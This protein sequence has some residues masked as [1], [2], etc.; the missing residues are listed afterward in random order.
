[1]PS[2]VR[3]L[4]FAV[5]VGAVALVA[6]SMGHSSATPRTPQKQQTTGESVARYAADEFVAA[7]SVRPKKLSE[8]A[9][10]GSLPIDRFLPDPLSLGRLDAMAVEEL[11]VFCGPAVDSNPDDSRAGDIEWAAA[12]RI[13]QSIALETAIRQWRRSV[14]PQEDAADVKPA[15]VQVGDYECFQVPA[16]SF[17]PPPRTDGE[18]RFT[19]RTG[20]PAEQGISVGRIY[21]Y[22]SYVEGSTKAS[23]IFTLDQLDEADLVDGHL[24][25][26]LRPDVFLTYFP[27]HEYSIAQIELRNP[28]SGLRSEPIKFEA[29]SYVNHRLNVPR[30]I[31]AVDARGKRQVDLVKDLVS[32]GRL[33]VIL[34]GTESGMYLGVGPHD[35]NVRPKAFE[36]VFVSGREIVVAQSR[37]TLQ[38][39]L[40]AAA[41]P[42]SLSKR[43]SQQTGDIV[44]TANVRD[45]SQRSA[46]QRLTRL[47]GENALAG[48]L[49]D[50]VT[51]VTATV[52]VNGPL[53]ARATANF[54]DR[55][56]AARATRQLN[57]MIR[58]TK[59]KAHANIG[60]SV[61]RLDTRGSLMSLF[62]GVPMGFPDF[63]SPTGK[64]REPQLLSIIDASLD[65]IR[66]ESDDNVLTVEFTQPASLSRLPKAAQ[67]AV[68]N[69]EE[70]LAQDL[71]ERER[72]D[73]GIEMY[74]RV[75]NRFPHVPQAWFR[76][77]H[78]LA[79]N[80]SVEFDG[81][82][83]RYAWVRRGVN[84]LLDGAEQNPDTTDHIWMAARFIGWKI[85]GSDERAA[86]RRL[87][88]QDERLHE[89]IA[90]VIDVKRARSPEKKVDNWLVAKL[91]FEHCVD[92]HAGSR[93]PST[94]PPVLF[95]SRPAASQAG[96]AQA[97]SESGHWNEALRAWKEAERLHK[98]LGERAIPV[99]AS[100]PIRLNDLES[101]LARSGP[102]DATV[103]RLR[104]AR[105]LI[106]YDYWLTRCRLEQ[107]TE[108]QL[109]RRLSHEAA[110]HARRSKPRRAYDLYRESLQ[111]LSEVHKRHP[112]EMAL[113]AGEFRHVAE[114][115]RKV[116]EMLSETD[117]QPLGT[118]L[119][120]IEQ[121]QPV[122]GTPVI[123]LPRPDEGD[124]EAP[125]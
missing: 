125:K 111:A 2:Q 94:I 95:F 124:S 41:T 38:K 67:F 12:A 102:K 43:L 19:D 24:P 50:A 71:F 29:K 98:E 70:V 57:Q 35:L 86:Y 113:V 79:Y 90:K 61:N 9:Y 53:T 27:D 25:L 58:S 85:G 28:D 78:H 123:G 39:M 97:L 8:H 59:A 56:N 82:E 68:A 106:Q 73:L 33:E 104:D 17:F 7:C 63:N 11:A 20:Q 108:V 110:E 49:G 14:V 74:Q 44:I 6:R 105:W 55:R 48:L 117:D 60:D 13:S 62:G 83:N 52:S 112:T 88:S 121:A 77:A 114:G 36:Y 3:I 64:A 109:A 122:S 21:E 22:R 16:G 84:V 72:F 76:R 118:I 47:M 65:N 31:A 75:T 81:Y 18:L 99:G 100:D 93:V 26:E 34:K 40:S 103:K 51:E 5:I 10:F 23:A 119:T 46:F 66:V 42:V 120:V 87:F 96:Y 89:R 80:T 107:T 91:L 1:M 69:M 54:E 92:R 37:K 32:N 15:A 101:R 30:K 116:A 4:S 45:R 115:Y